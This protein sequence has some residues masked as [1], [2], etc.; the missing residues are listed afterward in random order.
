MEVPLDQRNLQLNLNRRASQGVVRA[1][2]GDDMMIDEDDG[3]RER[4]DDGGREGA[5]NSRGSPEP[6]YM[7]S[8]WHMGRSSVPGGYSSSSS[9]DNYD[10]REEDMNTERE[11]ND[12]YNN[13]R[14]HEPLK[15]QQDGEGQGNKRR[16]TGD[17]TAI[18]VFNNVPAMTEGQQVIIEYSA[19]ATFTPLFFFLGYT[20]FAIQGVIFM[21]IGHA[22]QTALSTFGDETK[23]MRIKPWIGPLMH[24]LMDSYIWNHS[25]ITLML[26]YPEWYGAWDLAVPPYWL[27]VFFTM[28]QQQCYL[29]CSLKTHT[30]KHKHELT[31]RGQYEMQVHLAD[32]FFLYS[33]AAVSFTVSRIFRLPYL[34]YIGL[35]EF[36]V[37]PLFLVWVHKKRMDF[38]RKPDQKEETKKGFVFHCQR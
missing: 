15:R 1:G 35:V 17:T 6:W 28:A 32:T 22:L 16:R 38:Y 19:P 4:A 14:I 31:P 20:R 13:E 36:N 3:T 9:S 30:Q 8:F 37:A 7:R 2:G 25:A 26:L 21:Y 29:I 27:A 18:A 34:L 11:G 33:I 12:T 10:C 24:H 23:N 5:D